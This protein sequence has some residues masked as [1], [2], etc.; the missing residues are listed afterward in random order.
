MSTSAAH[1]DAFYTEALSARTV[2]A[3]RDADG[4]PAPV[5]RDG[6]RAMPF[7]SKRTRAER[8]VVGVPA[9][10]G[11]EVVDIALDTWRTR[12]LAGLQRDGLLVGLNW[13]GSGATGYEL[14]PAD[15][16]RNLAA[17]EP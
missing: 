14:P 3:V 8:I 4:F 12:W 16:L 11:F 7:W 5:N 13:S 15:V 2:W 10:A 6:V 1:A 17:R 9:Y